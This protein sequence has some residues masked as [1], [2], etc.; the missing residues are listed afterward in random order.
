MQEDVRK[1]AQR[2]IARCIV[3]L[4]AEDR[5][6]DL[7]FR[8][9]FQAIDLFLGFGWDVGLEGLH[10]LFDS[11]RDFFEESNLTATL[12]VAT[13]GTA[14]TLATVFFFFSSCRFVSYSFSYTLR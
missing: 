9:I 1:H 4:V 11:R 13:A 7:R 14:C 3:M 8:R 12:A 10:I 2:A 6:V 5:S